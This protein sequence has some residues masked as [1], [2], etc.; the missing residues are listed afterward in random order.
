MSMTFNELIIRFTTFHKEL[1][2]YMLFYKNRQNTALVAFWITL[3]WNTHG[4]WTQDFPSV[5]RNLFNDFNIFWKKGD[6]LVH[7]KDFSKLTAVNTRLN[8]FDS[9]YIFSN[10]LI[11]HYNKP[12]IL[13][14]RFLIQLGNN[15]SSIQ[16]V[17]CNNS[18]CYLQQ[19]R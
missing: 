11:K 17:S 15:K 7:I 8:E 2:T 9:L 19:V 18:I 10:L 16:Y 3:P 4:I 12:G 14:K 6:K 13:P 5:W 1:N